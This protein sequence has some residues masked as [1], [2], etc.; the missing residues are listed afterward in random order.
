MCGGIGATCTALHCRMRPS[1]D[2]SIRPSRAIMRPARG[3]RRR[4]ERPRVPPLRAP[5]LSTSQHRARRRRRARLST[6]AS[7]QRPSAHRG[8]LR[9]LSGCLHSCKLWPKRIRRNRDY[10]RKSPLLTNK[11][12]WHIWEISLR[13]VSSRRF[14]AK[15]RTSI[16]SE[17]SGRRWQDVSSDRRCA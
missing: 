8:V 13:E 15:A 4:A 1:T 14:C 6:Q 12:R 10:L 17:S 16:G 2:C 7:S 9:R 3:G 11:H 5:S